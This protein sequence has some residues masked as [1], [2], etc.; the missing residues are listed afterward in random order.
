M[1][2]VGTGISASEVTLEKREQGVLQVIKTS[3]F[4]S[5]QICCIEVSDLLH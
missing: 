2:L 5:Q 3:T 1:V 4:E